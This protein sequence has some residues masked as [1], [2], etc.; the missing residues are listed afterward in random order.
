MKKTRWSSIILIVMMIFT[1]LNFAP[2]IQKNVAAADPSTCKPMMGVNLEGLADYM[3]GDVFVD[4]MKVSRAWGSLSAPWTPITAVSENGWPLEDAG[5]IVLSS[6]VKANGQNRDISGIYKLSFEGTATVT[7]ANG[8]SL[9]I[10]NQVVKD[11][12]TTADVLVPIT[13]TGIWFLFTNTSCNSSTGKGVRNVHLYR[14]GYVPDQYGK[15]PTYTTE[16]L[17]AIEPFS[18]LRYMDILATN[19]QDQGSF[20]ENGKT[21]FFSKTQKDWADRK[22]PTDSSQAGKIRGF[23]G[24]AWEYIVELANL[25][26]KDLWINVPVNA[27]DDYITNLAAMLRDQVDINL[28]IYVEYSN[29]VWNWQ[30]SQAQSNL[31]YANNDP[32]LTVYGQSAYGV[33]FVERTAHISNLFKDAF[34]EYAMNDR[35]R[36]VLAW[37]QNDGGTF[38]GMLKKFTD[39]YPEY[40][41]PSDL[42]YAFATAPYMLEPLPDNCTS[43]AAVQD[44]ILKDSNSKTDDKLNLVATAKRWNIPGGVM[45]YEGG[46]HHQGQ[47][48]TN[49][50]IRVAAHREANMK[51]IV[52]NDIQNNWWNLGCKDFMYFSLSS[53]YGKYGCWGATES[54]DN[55]DAPKYQALLQLSQTPLSDIH[56]I[57]NPGGLVRNNGFEYDYKIWNTSNAANVL[58]IDSTSVHSGTKSLKITGSKSGNYIVQNLTYIKPNADYTLTYYTKGDN[59]NLSV[60]YTQ[61]GWKTIIDTS[62]GVNFDWTLKTV[63]FNTGTYSGIFIIMKDSAV[64]TIYYDDFK[65]TAD[66][67][68]NATPT[69]V[70]T[71]KPRV[72][73]SPEPTP[74]PTPTATPTPTPT[75]TPGPVFDENSTMVVNGAPAGMKM[76]ISEPGS[77]YVSVEL[78]LKGQMNINSFSVAIGYDK[79][80]VVPVMVAEPRAEAPNSK[81]SAPDLVAPYFTVISPNMLLGYNLSSFQMENTTSSSV[82]NYIFVAYAKNSGS[83]ISID[84]TTTVPMLKFYFRKIGALDQNTFSYYHKTIAS[85]V[86]SKLVYRNTNVLQSE[87]S[88]GTDIYTRPDLFTK[89]ILQI[90]HSVSLS[91]LTAGK[92]MNTGDTVY[93]QYMNSHGVSSVSVKASYLS[94]AILAETVID[95]T[96]KTGII[97]ALSDGNYVLSV[98]RDGYLTRR[99]NLNM[100]GSDVSLGEKSLVAG[101]AF[102]DGVI[103]GSDSEFLFSTIGNSYGHPGY[104]PSCD[105][106]QDGT[107]DGTDTETLFTHLGFYVMNYGE[108]INYYL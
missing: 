68:I 98:I 57:T 1:I 66:A 11:G 18:T 27:T 60:Y 2:N 93:D 106:N 42:F 74:T 80:K 108:G 10:T 41:N 77:G 78:K 45:A 79:T 83:T 53:V 95:P 86:V 24:V 22:L 6:T 35:V 30:F 9:T 52:L 5:I 96:S 84:G 103:D 40:G 56:V 90:G 99:V 59:G 28:N 58:S 12:I 46:P 20:V 16:F 55:F 7:G 85:T 72:T 102:V 15:Y 101:D 94:S 67:D 44:N 33:R 19:G 89:E 49:L 50:S 21:Y 34:G 29:E 54:Y 69:P 26:H 87:T 8:Y 43:I 37:Q 17:K 38:D 105:F 3:A 81:L 23:S 63:K 76:E 88:T 91:S 13:S 100:N 47:V 65:L 104:D 25:T 71:Q 75:P 36:C 14:P 32:K 92:I 48:D 73:P 107:I 64:S 70:V 51:N 39:T 4:V 61:S 97:P 82:G 31:Y 62:T